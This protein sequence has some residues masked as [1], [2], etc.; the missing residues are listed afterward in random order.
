MRLVKI[1]VFILVL[2]LTIIGQTNR[3]GIGG[4]VKDSNGAVVPNAKITIT[5]TGTKRSIS[6]TTSSDGTFSASS[7][8]PVGYDVLAEATNFKK[9]IIQMLR[10]TQLRSSP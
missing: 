5:N 10:S 6:L 7:L 8:E 3:G 9:A 1:S 4:T 2:C